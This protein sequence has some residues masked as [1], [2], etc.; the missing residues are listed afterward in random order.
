[1]QATLLLP[2]ILADATDRVAVRSGETAP[3]VFTY[4]RWRAKP[5][6]LLPMTTMIYGATGAIGGAIARNLVASGN[7]VHLVGRN[8][9][10][11]QSLASELGSGATVGDILDPEVFARAVADAGAPLQGLVYAVG[12]I[13]LK[14]LGRTSDEDMMQDFRL[15]ALGAA[16]AI[17]A[18]L[19]ALK[20]S[21][22]ASILLFSSVAAGLGFAS[23]ASIAMAK[24]AVEALT[25]SAAAE[26]APK[27]RVNC[28][29][30]SL[31]RT[32][33]SEHLTASEQMS[34]SLAQMHPLQRLGEVDD[35]VGLAELLLSP[36]SG[37]ITGQVIAVDGGRSR[38]AG[39]K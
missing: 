27:I 19:P 33:L 31:T 24:G 13:A 17:R 25:R 37:W 34:A 6:E 38:L 5:L 21:E 16:Q 18:A 39:K 32:P 28:I 12:S 20:A 8:A 29:A 36:K 11:L 7:T 9:E 22:Q 2:A 14:P 10:R 3:M 35:I 4:T 30:P 26:L 23:H 15:N 1:M